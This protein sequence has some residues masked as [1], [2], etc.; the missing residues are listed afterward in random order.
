MGGGLLDSA[1]RAADALLASSPRDGVAF[2]LAFDAGDWPEEAE[3]NMAL[4]GPEER[5][6][7]GRFRFERDRAT[8]VLAHAAWRVL[9]GRCL[10]VA[11]T[12]VPLGFAA[13]GQPQLAGT[14]WATSLSHSGTRVLL[15]AARAEA[16]GV[17]IECRSART[18]LDTLAEE[19]CTPAE[20]ACVRG[21]TEAGRE[22]ALLRLWTRKEALLKALGLG[23][24][25]PP[26]SFA[27]PAGLRI[28]LP[29]GFGPA[30][31]V[32]ELAAGAGW[33]GAWAAPAGV[34]QMVWQELR[35]VGL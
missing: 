25:Q 10:G 11:A 33:S 2:G 34:V 30:C 9:L 13:S 7:A 16:L 19:I 35:N 20:L 6:R 31:V 27:A 22:Q 26:S 12:E 15:A 24:R 28:D 29:G 1:G 14:G 17:D 8:Y 3:A 18:R 32:H 21:L 4:L 5:R 23:L